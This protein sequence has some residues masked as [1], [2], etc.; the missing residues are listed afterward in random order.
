MN[1]PSYVFNFPNMPRKPKKRNEVQIVDVVWKFKLKNDAKKASFN[2]CTSEENK[3]TPYQLELSFSQDEGVDA[4]SKVTQNRQLADGSMVYGKK[5]NNKLVML[6]KHSYTM[7][8]SL[9]EQAPDE[10][11]NKQKIKAY[12]VTTPSQYCEK[13]KVYQ[14][15][16]CEKDVEV[17]L[18]QIKSVELRDDFEYLEE[19][20]FRVYNDSA[21]EQPKK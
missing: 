4:R 9:F 14:T 1:T 2:F 21:K 12:L 20:T 7:M 10:N 15:P 16:N 18:D 19:F 13:G 3:R 17:E 5:E 6:R 11:G 8:F